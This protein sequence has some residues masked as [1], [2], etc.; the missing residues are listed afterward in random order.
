MVHAITATREEANVPW[1]EAHAL[2][3]R[4]GNGE[5]VVLLLQANSNVDNLATKLRT[6]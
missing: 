3:T 5:T 6:V 4:L 1:N 2:V